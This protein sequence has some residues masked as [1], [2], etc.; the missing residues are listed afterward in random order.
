MSICIVLA[1]KFNGPTEA[2]RPKRYILEALEKLMVSPCACFTVLRPLPFA[3]FLRLN[4]QVI[5][6]L[7]VQ[8]VTRKQ[9][10]ASEFSV[11]AR[12]D[13]SLHVPAPEVMF[14]FRRLLQ[15]S[16]DHTACLPPVP[17]SFIPC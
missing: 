3:F 7:L 11:F 5:V 8:R 16:C 13:F 10:L 2:A 9:L 14:H 4:R 1:F 17:L 12:L 15:V 6:C